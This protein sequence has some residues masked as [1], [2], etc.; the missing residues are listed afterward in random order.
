MRIGDTF[1]TIKS[2]KEGIA[3]SPVGIFSD[4]ENNPTSE[5]SSHFKRSCYHTMPVKRLSPIY[6]SLL[7]MIIDAWCIMM[8]KMCFGEYNLEIFL[9]GNI[10]WNTAIGITLSGPNIDDNLEVDVPIFFYINLTL[11]V[12]LKQSCPEDYFEIPK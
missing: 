12:Y 1:S 9:I 6:S 3:V 8:Q 4:L 7:F 11:T 5:F 10:S 2:V